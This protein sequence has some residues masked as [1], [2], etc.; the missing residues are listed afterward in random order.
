MGGVSERSQ[1]TS[2]QLRAGLG[3]TNSMIFFF[4]SAV[5]DVYSII[6]FC[7]AE[8]L[9]IQ[10]NKHLLLQIS[11]AWIRKVLMNSYWYQAG[12]HPGLGT[13]VL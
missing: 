3:K 1:T 4:L 10:R 2:G 11:S 9:I 5:N 6:L 13:T 7:H 8:I 12:L